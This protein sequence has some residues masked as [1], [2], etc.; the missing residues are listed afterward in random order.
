MPGMK[1]KQYEVAF[2]ARVAL[3]VVKGEK[4]IAQVASE[5]GVHPN[6]VGQ[7]KEHLLSILPEE[8]DGRGA[9]PIRRW[10]LPADGVAQGRE[11][12]A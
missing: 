2:K 11:R 5:Y 4:T 1:R 8:E 3:E 7:W 10:A 6:Q 12:L 9:Q